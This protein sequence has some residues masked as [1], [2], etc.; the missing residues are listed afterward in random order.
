LAG[1]VED[2]TEES[3]DLVGQITGENGVI[4]ALGAEADAVATTTGK[5]ASMRKEI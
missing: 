2:I 3:K 5:Y 1:K 4:S